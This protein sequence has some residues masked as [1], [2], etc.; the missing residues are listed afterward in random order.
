MFAAIPSREPSS[1]IQLRQ[2][3]IGLVSELSTPIGGSFKPFI[4]E[5][6]QPAIPRHLHI[7]FNHIASLSDRQSNRR[8]GAFRRLS[9]GSSMSDHDRPF[10]QPH[11][12][13]NR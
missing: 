4:V 2:S 1:G 6:N 8:G 7:E 11:G 10:F 9:G 13:G 3:A 12:T 5:N